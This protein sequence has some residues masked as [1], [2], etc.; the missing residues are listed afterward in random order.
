MTRIVVCVVV[1]SLGF[2]GKALSQDSLPP[3]HT[4]RDRDI[5]QV[6][7]APG[8]HTITIIMKNGVAYFYE[9]EDWDYEDHYSSVS[10][11]VK[12]AINQVTITFTRMEHN[13]E[14]PGGQEAWDKYMKEFCEKNKR[15][16]RAEGS[17]EVQVRF[18]VHMKGQ[19]SDVMV[20]PGSN[21]SGLERLA[22]RAIQ[23]SGPWSP[24]IQNGHKVVGYCTQTVK[25]TL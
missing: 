2:I 12:A 20:L 4:L 13:P 25:F 9:R 7:T 6:S 16:I 18:I 1:F 11:R 24:A 8:S 5:K 19:I 23:D 17:A 14:F 21:G 10:P 22:V 3:L 15:A